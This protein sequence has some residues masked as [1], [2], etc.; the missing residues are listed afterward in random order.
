MRQG[1]RQS[2]SS[3]AGE[4]VYLTFR[5]CIYLQRA[6]RAGLTDK[7][8]SQTAS[9][10]QRN[11]KGC[12]RSGFLTLLV[13]QRRV[14]FQDLGWRQRMSR[15]QVPRWRSRQRDET[16][17]Y[18]RRRH[19]DLTYPS[20]RLPGYTTAHTHTFSWQHGLTTPRCLRCYCTSSV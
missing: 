3:Q 19:L 5:Y 12:M 9:H 17:S 16:L 14:L 4:V 1:Q 8:P 15:S 11:A 6:D 2:E 18:T 20:I 13:Q 10:C 7:G